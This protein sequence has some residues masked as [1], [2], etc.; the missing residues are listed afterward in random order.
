M[1]HPEGTRKGKSR[2]LQTFG[3]PEDLQAED[4]AWS[5]GRCGVWGWGILEEKMGFLG[6]PP[7]LITITAIPNRDIANPPASDLGNASRSTS[8]YW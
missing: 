6:G 3:E 1:T 2:D 7:P 5:E 4:R 8:R